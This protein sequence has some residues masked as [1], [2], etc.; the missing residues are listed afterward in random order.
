MQSKANGRARQNY[1][2]GTEKLVLALLV[3]LVA[4]NA[5][6]AAAAWRTGP[7]LGAG[8]Y[9]VILWVVLRWK[10]FRASLIGGGVGTVVHLGEQFCWSGQTW[11]PGSA[12]LLTNAILAAAVLA[13]SIRVLRSPE[14]GPVDREDP[15]P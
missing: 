1:S 13:L 5:L 4:A 15:G 14:T 7:I 9:C 6:W 11:R 3:L 8:G 2:T 12:F 10:D